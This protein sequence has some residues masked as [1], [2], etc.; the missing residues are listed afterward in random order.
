MAIKIGNTDIS[1][2][3]VGSGDCKIYIGDTLL[4]PT[5]PSFDGKWLATY[6]DSHT[7]SAAC[8]ST[9]AITQNE[10]NILNLVSVEIGQCVTSIG[11][12]AFAY[13]DTLTSVDI[14]NIVTSIGGSAF[15][16]CSGLTSIDIPN[17]V[18]SIGGSAFRFCRSLTS[19]TIGSGVTSIGS[20]AFNYCTSLPSITIPSGVTVIYSYAFSNCSSLTSIT[21]NAVNPPTLGSMTGVFDDTNECP[22]YVPAGSVSAY[23]AAYGWSTY[24]NRIQAIP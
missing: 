17:N 10:I 3:K 6:S 9:S 18:T 19:C 21:C 2:F 12:S 13:C 20:S 1:A 11:Q 5:T 7:E 14:P 4:Y 22:I 23:K 24:A 8:N 15:Y 16:N